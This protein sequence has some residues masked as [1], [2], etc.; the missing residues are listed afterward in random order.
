MLN[1]FNKNNFIPFNKLSKIS[2]IKNI[3]YSNVI[4]VIILTYVSDSTF[5]YYLCFKSNK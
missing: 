3:S 2:L 4:K 5:I 1:Y